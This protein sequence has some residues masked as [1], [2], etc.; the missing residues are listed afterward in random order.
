MLTDAEK[1][2]TARGEYWRVERHGGRRTDRWRV[3]AAY[4]REANGRWKFNELKAEMRQ[5]GVRLYRPDG[6]LADE[7]V[8]PALR[9]RW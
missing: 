3:V 8:A 4:I 1:T 9:T 7:V 5:G 2:R 6:E